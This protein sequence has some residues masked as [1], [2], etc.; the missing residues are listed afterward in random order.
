MRDLYSEKVEAT[1]K[2]VD[3]TTESPTDCIDLFEN[4]KIASRKSF[5]E[6]LVWNLL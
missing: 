6:W 3:W 4:D 2:S 1:M 5:L